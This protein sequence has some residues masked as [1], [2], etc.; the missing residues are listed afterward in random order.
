MD[1][2]PFATEEFFAR[3][4]FSAPHSLSSSDCESRTI[5]ELLTLAKTS[6]E[7]LT[8]LDLAYTESQGD[9][10]L[11]QDIAQTYGDPIEPQHI[12]VLSAPHEGI[13]ITMRALLEPGDEVVVLSPCYDSL[14]QVAEHIGC[15]VHRW[16]LVP[17]GT[18]WTLDLDALSTLLPR[19]RMLVLNAPHNPTGF[20]PTPTQWQQVL[21]RAQQTQTLVFSDEM[22]RGLELYDRP[23]L[24]SAPHLNK[25]SIALT[26]LSKSYGLPGLRSG[27]LVVREEAV[28]Q[29]IL[30]WKNYTTI[31]AP[32]PSEWLARQALSVRHT[33]WKEHQQQIETNIQHVHKFIARQQGKFTWRP[34]SAGSMALLETPWHNAVPHCHR[35]G[36]EAGVLVLPGS[37]LGASPHTIRLGLGRRNF[38][39]ALEVWENALRTTPP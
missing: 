24:R 3:Y 31:C 15:R 5:G 21:E 8:S 20:H 23:Q 12:V 11:R 32:A 7:A 33:L 25:T 39:Q 36:R 13:Y 18:Q 2:T 29:R 14:A 9:P 26:G 17:D 34:P 37:F 4:E 28:R 35:W 22:Y 38:P 19:A 6:P 10:S 27:W 1:I 30:A 16:Q